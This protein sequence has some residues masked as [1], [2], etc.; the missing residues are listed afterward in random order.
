MKLHRL[1][2]T[3]NEQADVEKIAQVSG[4]QVAV[5]MATVCQSGVEGSRTERT[6]L[7]RTILM[8]LG[9]AREG[10]NINTKINFHWCKAQHTL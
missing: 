8:D 4:D 9:R 3:G 5:I 7:Q 2:L 10:R 1:E 6:N